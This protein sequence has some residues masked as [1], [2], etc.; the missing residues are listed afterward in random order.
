MW[1]AVGEA[2]VS[3]SGAFVSASRSASIDSQNAVLLEFVLRTAYGAFAS[4]S[5]SPVIDLK[6]EC[7]EAVALSECS[8][9]SDAED[10]EES[11]SE[12]PHSFAHETPG[13]V[14]LFD[15]DD[16]LLASSSIR[17]VGRHPEEDA[18]R[19]AEL[20]EAVLRAARAV[21]R[22]SIVTMSQRPWVTF[23]AERYLPGLDLPSLLD[24][25]GIGVYYALEEAESCPGALEAKNCAALKTSAMAQSLD[26]MCS[27]GFFGDEAPSSVISIGDSEAERQALTELL[28]SV[29][30]D[31]VAE[32]PRCKTVKFVSRPTLEALGDELTQLLPLLPNMAK[33][34]KDFDLCICSPYELEAKARIVGL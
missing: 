17:A 29:S 32:R 3:A 6:H 34:K 2:F 31:D 13:A 20:V 15:W 9:S 22:V 33:I 8:T 24:E 25:L 23:S 5:G 27:A 11:D 7:S 28:L 26:D 18:I 30:G 16:T 1:A 10:S 12:M 4:S 14:I 21:A 19:H